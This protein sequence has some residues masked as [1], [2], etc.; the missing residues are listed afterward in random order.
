MLVVAGSF[1]L[2][3]GARADLSLET[4]SARTLAPGKVEVSAAGE[5]QTAKDG[6]EVALPLAIDIGVLPRLEV[7][8]EPTNV[9]QH[10]SGDRQEDKWCR[11]YG[12]DRELSAI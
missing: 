7:L 4:E 5:Y 11:R 10:K 12:T 8:I 3:S 2:S 9:R 6:G 1:A